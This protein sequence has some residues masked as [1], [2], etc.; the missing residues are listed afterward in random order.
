MQI[1]TSKVVRS[2]ACCQWSPAN[3]LPLGR[4]QARRLSAWR[5][6]ASL[7]KDWGVRRGRSPV[8]S[9]CFFCP[10]PLIWAR[11]DPGGPRVVALLFGHAVP[12]KTEGRTFGRCRLPTRSPAPLKDAH[13]GTMGVGTS[14]S[15]VIFPLDLSPSG[16]R[17]VSQPRA[18][19]GA[20]RGSGPQGSGTPCPPQRLT[21]QMACSR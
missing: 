15:R 9:V 1:A 8:P 5:S 21:A 16:W 3:A 13:G 17:A 6:P 14:R 11:V 2:A 10:V 7:H 20:G 4:T 12:W 18:C 19:Y